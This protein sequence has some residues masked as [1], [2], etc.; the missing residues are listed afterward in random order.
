MSIKTI[1]EKILF[2]S[3]WLL[4][5]FYLGLII[6]Q[7]C[8]AWVFLK[9]IL[10]IFHE[11]NSFSK[12]TILIT[13]LELVDMVM[14]ANLVKMIITGSYNSSVSKE[15]GYQGENITSGTMKIK[16]GSSL[17]GVSSIHLLQTFL[18]S[19]SSW[20]D[21][22]KQLMIHFMFIIGSIA[23]S[24]I[25]YLHDKGEHLN[26]THAP[27]PKDKKQNTDINQPQH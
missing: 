5:L 10:H 9:E 14:I 23:L 3:K 20:D 25:E 24:Y 11:L 26:P 7:M 17:I 12:E 13:L 8:Y 15:H 6:G 21:I 22:Y 16:M 19:N 27:T 1:T 2:G 4:L 18:N